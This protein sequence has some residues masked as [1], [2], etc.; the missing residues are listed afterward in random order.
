MVIIGQEIVRIEQCMVR[1]RQEMVTIEA[2]S[3]DRAGN[4]NNRA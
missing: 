2:H 3:Q 4:G 1:I